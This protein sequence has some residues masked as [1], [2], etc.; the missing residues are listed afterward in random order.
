MRMLKAAVLVALSAAGATAQVQQPLEASLRRG[1]GEAVFYVSEPAYVAVFEV[2]PGQGV[3]QVFPRSTFQSQRPVEPG[4]YL[5][6]R[7]F[8]SSYSY[9]GWNNSMPYARPVYMLDG[10]GRIAS[11]YYTTAWT[12][13]R[14]IS[15]VRTYLLVASRKPFR[16][17]SGPEA[18][19]H[20]LQQ[21]VG[22]SAISNTVYAPASMLDD[23]VDA[24]LPLGTT[25]DDVVVDELQLDD[26]WFD[27]RRWAGRSISFQCP[28]GM[29]SVP[30]EFFFGSGM[31][32][33]PAVPPRQ[34]TPATAGPQPTPV[35]P[36]SGTWELLKRPGR[37]V[38]P[39]T[40]VE[41]ENV[42]SFRRGVIT[43]SAS[44]GAEVDEGY[45]SLRRGV[46]TTPAATG[47]P[48]PEGFRAYRRSIASPV[49]PSSA[50][51]SVGVTSVPA[52]EG[53]TR[54]GVNPATGAWVPP[55]PS[56]SPNDYGYGAGRFSPAGSGSGNGASR[57]SG[58]YNGNAG[59]ATYAT[60]AS[61][62]PVASPAPAPTASQAQA[63]RSAASRTEVQAARPSTVPPANR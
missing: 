24:I 37:K 21:V 4:E 7:P 38:P 53:Y 3:Q 49:A 57:P 46:V 44:P 56:L 22:F 17:V 18:A 13:A 2:I 42:R 51:I 58:G 47:A 23:I 16:R 26:S 34:T 55:T 39:K 59:T 41:P 33:C 52:I 60:P 29:Y 48:E 6:S 43:T 31:F 54:H 30:A 5:L 40:D 15:P 19:Q 35:P 9:Y 14:M 62:A 12:D 1:A 50:T 11:Y 8:R 63:E 25:V 10:G 20:W 36:D 27:D 28:G 61:T 32:W 45:R